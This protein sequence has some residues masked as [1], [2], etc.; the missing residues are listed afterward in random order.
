MGGGLLKDEY[1]DDHDDDQAWQK[2]IHGI[3]EKYL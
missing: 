1:D 3:R 2:P